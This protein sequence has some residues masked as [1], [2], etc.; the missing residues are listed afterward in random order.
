MPVFVI[1]L[2]AALVATFGFW[3][4]LKAILG[5]NRSHHPAVPTICRSRGWN[6]DA[7]LAALGAAGFSETC[8]EGAEPALQLPLLRSLLA[9]S[10][11]GRAR[12]RRPA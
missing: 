4:T 11:E 1:L 2:L 10:E 8:L 6:A 12:L 5:T 3:S 7:A 9:P